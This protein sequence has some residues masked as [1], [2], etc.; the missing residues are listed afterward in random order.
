MFLSF[1]Q[2]LEN[3]LRTYFYAADRLTKFTVTVLQEIIEF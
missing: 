1:V 2:S 3:S